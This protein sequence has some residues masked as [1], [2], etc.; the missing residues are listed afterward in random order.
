MFRSLACGEICL[1][2]HSLEI[3]IHDVETLN[4]KALERKFDISKL[5]F[6]AWLHC[7][8][9]YQMLSVGAALGY[10]CGPLVVTKKETAS[11]SMDTA[12]VAIPGELTTAY[13][14]FRLWA[15]DCKNPVFTAYD[16]IMDMV[17]SGQ[18]DC[19]VLI[20]ESRFVYEAYGLRVLA[21]LGDWWDTKTH[22]P[23]PLGCIAASRQL[24]VH[25]IESFENKLR[26]SILCARKNPHPAFEY[27]KNYARE[28]DEI[29]LRQHVE[30]FVNDKSLELGSDGMAA[31]N[32]LEEMA[33]AAGFMK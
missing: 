12:R 24:P 33:N 28:L 9:E 18:A 29:V 11:F 16:N 8:Q 17:K 25:L 21:D 19:G 26:E 10:G 22:L 7:K 1:D 6:Q 31:V 2:G 4:Q 23:I 15:P 3:H 14:L 5:S 30:T 27:A 20:H 32:K 13:L